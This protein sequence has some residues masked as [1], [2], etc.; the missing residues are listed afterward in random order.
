[1]R[2]SKFNSKQKAMIVSEQSEG[3]SIDQ[4]CRDHQISAATFHKW[5]AELTIEQDDNKR[6]LDQ[7]EK[8]N[9][10]LKK[11]YSELSMDHELLKEGYEFLK[12]IRAQRNEKS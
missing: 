11:M 6:R 5:K 4:I 3:K 10:R 1:M 2:A 12:K 7:L 9:A 8:E